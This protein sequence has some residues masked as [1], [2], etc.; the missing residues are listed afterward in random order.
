LLHPAHTA[1]LDALDRHARRR[2]GGI[3]TLSALVGPPDQAL[4]L[5]TA[6]AHRRGVSVAVSDTEE[7]RTMVRAWALAL[8]RERALFLDAEAFVVLH[9]PPGTPRPLFFRGKT[10]H[11]RGLLL[12]ALSPPPAQKATWELCRQLLASREFPGVGTLPAEVEAAIAQ[13]PFSALRALLGLVPARGAPVLRIHVGIAELGR[14][15]AAAALGAAAPSLTL[16]CVLTPEALAACQHRGESRALAMLRE[17]LLELPEE[18]LPGVASGAVA[19]M[20]ARFHQEGTP[21]PL[22]AHYLEAA[23]ALTTGGPD[24]GG[25]AR[26]EAERFLFELL[27]HRPK[28][29]GLFVLNGL[30]PLDTGGRPWEVDLLCRELRLAVELDGY[31]HFRGA[32]D[33]RRDRRKDLALQRQGYWVVRFLAEDVVARLEDILDTLDTLIDARRLEASQQERP[34]GHR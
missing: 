11:E 1:L 10:A 23:R 33:F 4:A 3:A 19:P 26:S 22:V 6:W 9:A 31:F 21:E 18:A 20:L 32:E 5:F 29:R 8:A 15:H 27:Q 14:L 7:P 12:D 16:V 24:A 30:V 2:E 25:R 28:T 34:H 17:G 13:E